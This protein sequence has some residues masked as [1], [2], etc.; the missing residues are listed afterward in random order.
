MGRDIGIFPGNA[1][2][3]FYSREHLH[4]K[5]SFG[6]YP[7]ACLNNDKLIK[8]ETYKSWDFENVWEMEDGVSF[9]K[10]RKLEKMLKRQ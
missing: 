2:N 3:S 5:N 10:L 4:I 6:Q 1:E 9:P 8:K 7:K